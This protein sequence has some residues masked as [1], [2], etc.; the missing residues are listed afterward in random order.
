MVR[1]FQPVI[2]GAFLD[3]LD[4][5]LV[6]FIPILGDI[7]D[8]IGVAYFWRALGPVSLAGLVELLP[9]LDILPTYTALGVLAYTGAV[10]K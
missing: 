8:L 7:V 4:Y 2:V 5:L 3:I 9:G 1:S 10:R 6:G